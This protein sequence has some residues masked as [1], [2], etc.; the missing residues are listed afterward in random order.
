MQTRCDAVNDKYRRGFLQT[1]AMRVSRAVGQRPWPQPGHTV[2]ISSRSTPHYT[3]LHLILMHRRRW[4]PPYLHAVAHPHQTLDT[5]I[6]APSTDRSGAV[7]PAAGDPVGP[8]SVSR[9]PSPV[10]Y[11]HL[12]ASTCFTAI[13]SIESSPS[14]CRKLQIANCNLYSTAH[15]PPDPVPV[16]RGSGPPIPVCHFDPAA[17]SPSSRQQTLCEWRDALRGGTTS[18]LP[19]LDA[20]L[21]LLFMHHYTYFPAE[22]K[23]GWTCT[24]GVAIHA[25]MVHELDPIAF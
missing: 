24:S 6:N 22:C 14:R 3:S 18:R 9:L 13:G 20:S 7:L 19:E 4:A 11:A 21:Q 15:K 25:V 2:A 16:R 12:A 5:A 8:S 1:L 23:C 10:L 17:Q